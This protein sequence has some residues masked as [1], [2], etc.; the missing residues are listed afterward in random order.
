MTTANNFVVHSNDTYDVYCV[1]RFEEPI[2]VDGRNYY[3]GY[4]VVHRHNG[5]IEY[6][7]PSMPDAVFTSEHN[8]LTLVQEQWKWLSN[9]SGTIVSPGNALCSSDVNPD[10]SP[11]GA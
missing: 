2:R 4:E 10:G 8:N 11:I 3:G 1:S 6:R 9:N 7:T 5:I